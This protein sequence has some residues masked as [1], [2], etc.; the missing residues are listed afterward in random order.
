LSY[1]GKINTF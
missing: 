1:V